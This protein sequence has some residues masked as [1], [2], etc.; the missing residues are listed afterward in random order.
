MPIAYSANLD[1]IRTIAV[2]LV[3]VSHLVLQLTNGG[4]PAFYSVRTMG[5]V[6]VAI[7]FVHTTLVLMASLARHG[8]AA[9]PFHVRSTSRTCWHWAPSMDW[10]Q[11]LRSCSGQPCWFCCLAWPMSAITASRSTVSHLTRVSLIALLE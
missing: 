11:G 2:L 1:G 7:F 3:V 4:E 5:R 8:P 9:I 10:Y 6:G